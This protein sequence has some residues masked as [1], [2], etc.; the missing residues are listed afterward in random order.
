MGKIIF[1]DIDGTI[2]WYDGSVPESTIF[3]IKAARKRGHEICICSGRPYSLIEKNI[4]DIGFD[5]V[6]SCAEIGRAHV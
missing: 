6:V 2:R 3:A 4:M 1:L 5:G